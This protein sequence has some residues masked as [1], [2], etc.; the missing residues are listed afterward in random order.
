MR[1]LIWFVVLCAWGMAL[2]RGTDLWW[3]T[4]IIA[5]VSGLAPLIVAQE[6]TQEVWE[7]MVYQEGIVE[8]MMTPKED[9]DD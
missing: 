1:A 4:A 2:H 8:T 9:Y 3:A 6:L 5:T 7:S